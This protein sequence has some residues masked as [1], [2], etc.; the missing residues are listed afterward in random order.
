MSNEPLAAEQLLL[1]CPFCGGEV[2]PR[3]W[4]GGDGVRGPECEECG[5]TAQS[6]ED[7][8]KRAAAEPRAVQTHHEIAYELFENCTC[9]GE[10]ECAYCKSRIDPMRFDIGVHFEQLLQTGKRK[11]L[12]RDALLENCEDMECMICATAICPHGEPLHFHHDG[13]PACSTSTKG[14]GL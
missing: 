11:Q 12:C 14:E 2:D 1:P 13:C 9:D 6:M 5:A 3:G 7:W 8:N 4:L 10:T